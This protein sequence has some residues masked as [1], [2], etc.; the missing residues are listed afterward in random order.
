MY[1]WK[2]QWFYVKIDF[3]HFSNVQPEKDMIDYLSYIESLYPLKTDKDDP[4]AENREKF[5][6]QMK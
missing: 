3:N 5:N 4:D 1:E 2:L 6:K